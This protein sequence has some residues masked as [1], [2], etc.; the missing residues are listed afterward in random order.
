MTPPEGFEG[1]D[2]QMPEGMER[3]ERPEGMERPEGTPGGKTDA[4]PSTAFYMNDL[5]NFFSGVTA[6]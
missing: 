1:F 2:G 5:V 3:P 6:A 4:E